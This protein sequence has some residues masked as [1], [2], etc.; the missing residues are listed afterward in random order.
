MQSPIFMRK[1]VGYRRVSSRSQADNFS[2]RSQDDDI[3]YHSENEGILL[4]RMFTDI[5]S[6][7]STKQRPQFLQMRE[8]ALDPAN[9]I[10]DV[11]SG[12]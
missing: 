12:T 7:L 6:G 3:R 4:D 2:L 1:G 10:T 8:Y 5:G 9:G 11:I